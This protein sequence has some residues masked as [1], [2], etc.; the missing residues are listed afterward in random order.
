SIGFVEGYYRRPRIDRETLAEHAAGLVCLSACLTGE[1]ALWLRSGNHDKARESACWHARLF[2][3]G[4]YWLEVQDHGIADEKVVQAGVASLAG[5]LGLGVV[6]PHAA[7]Y[8]R[9]EDAA[10]HDVL[11]AIG[12]GKDLSDP[13]RFRFE[14]TESY[15][16]S[17]EE[18][19]RLF[20][21]RDDLFANTQLIADRCEFDFEKRHYI[22]EF[23]RPAEY[24]TDGDLLVAL[25]REGAKRRYGDPLPP[26]AQERLDY[27]LDVVTSVGYS[28]YFL[29]VADFIRWA[30]E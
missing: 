29:I 22:P 27:E 2:G 23:P 10:A 17:E 14:G 8:L 12:T 7:H 30:R 11:L 26:A 24:A 5:E 13:K 18:M 3:E 4:N 15:V 9:R 21:G 20:P 25:A 6:A 19:R 16:K 28:G 1:V